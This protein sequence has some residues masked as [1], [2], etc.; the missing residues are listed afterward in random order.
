MEKPKSP[1]ITAREHSKMTRSNDNMGKC[2]E[3]TGTVKFKLKNID[4]D[5]SPRRKCGKVKLRTKKSKLPTAKHKRQ[6][7]KN[8]EGVTEDVGEG[9]EEPE[10][11][12]LAGEKSERN[13]NLDIHPRIKNL[14]WRVI[15]EPHDWYKHTVKLLKQTTLNKNLFELYCWA[16][17]TSEKTRNS[18][19]QPKGAKKPQF[20]TADSRYL[21]SVEGQ[22][23][24]TESPRVSMKENNSLLETKLKKVTRNRWKTPGE[25][26]ILVGREKNKP[27]ASHSEIPLTLRCF[28][29]EMHKV[30]K[31]TAASSY[32]AYHRNNVPSV[33]TT[34]NKIDSSPRVYHPET[35]EVVRLSKL[36][37]EKITTSNQETFPDA[38][39]PCSSEFLHDFASTHDN[40]ED[41]EHY[42]AVNRYINEHID[43][44]KIA[45]PNVGISKETT[46]GRSKLSRSLKK[47]PRIYGRH[48]NITGKAEH[49]LR[50]RPIPGTEDKANL[51]AKY[52]TGGKIGY[53]TNYDKLAKCLFP[54]V[55]PVPP[56]PP[57]CSPTKSFTNFIRQNTP[58]DKYS[59]PDVEASRLETFE[60][61]THLVLPSSKN[62]KSP[63]PR[64][65]A[66][67]V[68]PEYRD[69][70][71]F[72]VF[73][74]E[75]LYSPENKIN[76]TRLILRLPRHSICA[77]CSEEDDFQTES[78]SP[79][80]QIVEESFLPPLH[81]IR[82]GRSTPADSGIITPLNTPLPSSNCSSATTGLTR[83]RS[84]V[85]KL[86]DIKL[87]P[88]F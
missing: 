87:H 13:T 45:N 66:L 27:K 46:R 44:V 64:L 33:S 36:L 40:V 60:D 39:D 23:L 75:D 48:Q 1:R 86:P 3:E 47:T 78:N 55:T 19:R 63:P 4:N 79:R 53:Q 17:R 67:Y 68:S 51:K 52:G 18:P 14:T 76:P 74:S 15:K 57:P 69:N 72:I 73:Q 22:P 38:H 10:E 35:R 80:E 30:W 81:G 11:S 20:T 29:S 83:K 70:N 49:S 26:A 24:D 28:A 71:N 31:K 84:S 56:C 41:L 34:L 2:E 54:P 82:I 59:D 8:Q 9:N 25:I 50:I 77:S 58:V 42:L 65:D 37:N 85:A 62:A 32:I 61:V 43:S 88:A 6:Q 5:K 12:G 7:N 21:L 16:A